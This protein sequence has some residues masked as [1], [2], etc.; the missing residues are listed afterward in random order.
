[1]NLTLDY[2]KSSRKWL[3]PNLLVYGN[4]D[5][6]QPVFL[7]TEDATAKRIVVAA[8]VIGG[9]DQQVSYSELTDVRGN[10]IPSEITSPVVIIIPRNEV[11]CYL[12]GR[13]SSTGFKIAK[14]ESS[15]GSSNNGLVDLM[16]M[17]VDLP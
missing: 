1:M 12:V 11:F 9:K 13:P 14:N 17:E 5:S 6:Y 16:I 8:N 10:A 4:A 3:A 15:N 2:L 7:L